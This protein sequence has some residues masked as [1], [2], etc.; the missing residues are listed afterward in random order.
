MVTDERAVE[1]QTCEHVANSMKKALVFQAIRLLARRYRNLDDAQAAKLLTLPQLNR[2]YK[3]ELLADVL[4]PNAARE[5]EIGDP[6][7]PPLFGDFNDA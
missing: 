4:D 5:A 3:G 7:T 1:N 2:L 6:E